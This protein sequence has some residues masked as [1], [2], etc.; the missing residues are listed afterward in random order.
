M[1]IGMK[2]TTGAIAGLFL[3]AH[4]VFRFGIEYVRGP[5][6]ILAYSILV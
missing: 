6:S 5:M 3:A 1:F 2:T 4:G